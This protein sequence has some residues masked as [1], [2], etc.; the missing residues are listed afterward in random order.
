MTDLTELDSLRQQ[1]R[2]KADEH[3]VALQAWRNLIRVNAAVNNAV[4][5]ALRDTD[6]PLT[7]GEVLIR[8]VGMPGGSMRMQDLADQLIFSRSGVT[9]LIDRIQAA[10]L[11]RR[12]EA[13]SDRRGT[14]AVITPEGR[15]RLQESLPWVSTVIDDKFSRHLTAREADSLRRILEKLLHAY[16]LQEAASV[17]T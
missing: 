16:G 13:D 9:R 11:I 1:E 14:L 8:L 6:L 15:S 4:E 5:H 12:E 2:L 3:V 7:W 17:R 10:G